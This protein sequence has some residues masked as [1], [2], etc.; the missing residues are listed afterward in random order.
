MSTVTMKP[1]NPQNKPWRGNPPGGSSD[2]SHLLALL[3]DEAQ[4][5]GAWQNFMVQALFGALEADPKDSAAMELLVQVLH[6]FRVRA[7]LDPDALRPYPGLESGLQR[8]D[9]AIGRIRETGLDWS[10]PLSSLPHVL[11]T[12]STGSGK[13]NLLYVILHQLSGKIPFLYVTPKV[14]VARL[15]VDPR[16]FQRVLFLNEWRLCLFHSPGVPQAD[17][18]RTVIEIFAQD[19]NL[20][21]SRVLFHRCADRLQSLYD[22]YSQQ[23][24]TETH[25]TLLNLLEAVRREK[26]KYLE[27]AETTIDI[28]IRATGQLLDTSYGMDPQSLFGTGGTALMIPNLNDSRAAR[29]LIDWLIHWLHAYLQCHGPNDSSPQ[30]VLVLDD[31]QRFLGQGLDKDGAMPLSHMYLLARQAG[32]RFIASS[33]SPSDLALAVSSQSDLIVNTG[34]LTHQK[35]LQAMGNALGLPPSHWDRLQSPARGEFV[36]R[37]KLGRYSRPFAGTVRQF[38]APT[39]TFT[40]ADRAR[41][42]APVLAALPWRPGVPLQVVER[43]LTPFG[44][45]AAPARM[46]GQISQTAKALASDVLDHPWD[47]LNVRYARLGLGGGSAQRSKD[48]L[49]ALRWVREW[50]VPI[51][52]RAPILL[53]PLP[54]LAAALQ[55]SIPSYGKG[56]FMH[57]FGIEEVMSSMRARG[58]RDL[59]KEC[60]FGSKA[61]DVVGVDPTGGL[62]GVEVTLSLTNACDNAEKD[63]MVASLA[64]LVMVCL[65]QSD[66]R[67][68]K[69][70][71]NAAPGLQAFLPRITVETLAQ[72]I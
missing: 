41:L 68:V 23:C 2:P 31:A 60:F 26:S 9:N 8:G 25:F 15:L 71:L 45:G 3:M 51:K 6:S 11:L 40:E 17:W 13:T 7:V 27:G 42:M 56:G 50:S 49:L 64:S 32:L 12:G 22:A 19:W 61:I 43:A 21:Y 59:R 47:F 57:A 24:G 20:Q 67:Q 28:T 36:A 29:F 14:D 16:V 30:F 53:E 18:N 54:T 69:R 65:S 63:F 72:W 52:G 66:V 46:P 1:N 44:T 70:A 5:L 62:V 4:E 58:Y 55:R 48:E 38:P 10:I 39:Q 34:S 37:E 35:D 33:Q